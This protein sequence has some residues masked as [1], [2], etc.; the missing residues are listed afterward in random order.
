TFGEHRFDW[1]KTATKYYYNSESDNNQEC[2][3][4]PSEIVLNVWPNGDPG[5]SQGPPRSNVVATVEYIKLYFNST[6]MDEQKFSQ[7]CSEA[8]HVARC[9]I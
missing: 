4:L 7:A 9:K 2:P 3:D 1:L 6:S 5:F 8:G